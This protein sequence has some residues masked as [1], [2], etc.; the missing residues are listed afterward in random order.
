MSTQNPVFIPGPTNIPEDLRRACD[1]PTVDHRSAAFPPILN[2][3]RSGVQQVIKSAE[4]EVFIFPGTGTGG[5]EV[6]L[7]NTIAPGDHVLAARNGMFSHKWIDMAQ[8]HGLEVTVVDVPWGEGIPVA[9][10]EEILAGDTAHEIKAV[11]ATHNETATAVTSYNAGVRRAIE[12]A[13][14]TAL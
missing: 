3:A 10:F 5:W 6:A 11:L 7:T 9:R 4:A 1:L 14:H 2:A 8:R 12:A 13:G